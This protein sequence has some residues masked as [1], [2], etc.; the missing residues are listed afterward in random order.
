MAPN[1]YAV[2][3]RRRPRVWFLAFALISSFIFVL[4]WRAVP[5]LST[6]VYAENTSDTMLFQAAPLAEDVDHNRVH[7]PTIVR[8]RLVTVNFATAVEDHVPDEHLP[9]TSERLILNLFD[10]ATFTAT[11]ERVEYHS[12][13]NFTW[14]GTIEHEPQSSVTLVFADGLLVGNIALRNGFYQIRAIDTT[15]HRILQI[16]QSAFPEEDPP[17]V[18]E[19]P[20]DTNSA[21][22]DMTA[23]DDG[24]VIDVMIV[25]TSAARAAEG[26]TTAIRNLLDLIV[27][28]TN[29]GYANSGITQR[30]NLVHMAEVSYSETS[31]S[32]ID[33]IA[34]EDPADGYMDAVHTWRDT[35][36]ADI[37][38]LITESTY[39]GRAALMTTTTIDFAPKAFSV[40]SRTCAS[41]NLSVP[42]EM[43]HN[44]GAQHDRPYAFSAIIYDYAY[45]YV[46]PDYSFR[47]VMAYFNSCPS[48]DCP[49]INYWSNP[50]VT[51]NG[52]ST[53][54]YYSY[55]NAADNRRTLNNTAIYAANW[56]DSSQAPPTAPSNLNVTPVSSTQLILSWNDNSSNESGFEIERAP[57]GSGNWN[58]IATIP[59]N[60]ESYTDNSLT[61]NT[62]YEYR[63]RAYNSS[64][65]S[66]YSNIASATTDACLPTTYTIEGYVND[67]AGNGIGGITIDFGGSQP[68]VTTDS[69]GF[70]SQSG[71]DDGSYIVSVNAISYAFSPYEDLIA[72]SGSDVTHNITGYSF[73]PISPPFSDDFESGSL[74][75]AWA[76]ETDYEGRVQVSSSYPDT[77]S[78]SLLLDD[79][80]GN[81]VKSHAAALLALDLSN[82]SDIDFSFT[83]REF[84]DEDDLDDGVFISDDN[85]ATWQQ[86]FSFN[87]GP[88]TF[89]QETIDLDAA[90]S[91]AGM[92]L[93]SQ[94]LVKF[95]FYDD[96]SV[97]TDGYAIDNVQISAIPALPDTPT[98]LSA[99][100]TSTSQIHLDWI[101]TSDNEDGFTIERSLSDTVG[102]WT[103]IAT[104]GSNAESYDDS[105]LTC[106]TTYYYRISAYNAAG[107][108]PFS[109]VMQTHTSDCPAT[110]YTIE[111]YV[112]D[113]GGN[114]ITGVTVDFAGAQ[115]VVT[116]DSSGYYSQS[117]FTDGNYTVSADSSGYVFSPYEDSV[118]VSSSNVIHDI[119]G[120]TL[121]PVGLPFSDG[122]E[123]GS[124]SSPWAIETDYEG[125]VEISSTYPY[126]GN[127]SLLLDDAAGNL[128][129]SHAAAILALD[130]SGQSNVDLSFIWRGFDDENDTD[131]GIFI[132]DDNGATWQQVFSFNNGPM[133]FTQETIDLD[134]AASAAGRSL[135]S[136]FLVKFQFYDNYP[137]S[138]DGYA[139]DSVQVTGGTTSTANLSMPTF[140]GNPGETIQV[141]IDASDVQGLLATDM[142]I[143]YDSA[144]LAAQSVSTGSLT[145]G[146][147]QQANTTTP[148]Q[149]VI[150]MAGALPASGNGTLATIDFLITGQAGDTSPLQFASVLLNDGAMNATTTDGFVTVN[151][152]SLSGAIRFWNTNS[153]VS[154]VSVTLSGDTS[155]ATS[156]D[157]GG[158]YTLTNLAPGTYT[159]TP[160]RTDGVNGITSFD[161]SLVLQHAVGTTP[162]S[163]HAAIAADVNKSGSINSM[164]AAYIMQYSVG[165]IT[166]PFPGAGTIWEFDLP[167]HS[168]NPLNSSQGNQDFTAIL[169]G[170]PSG[171]WS[172]TSSAPAP[173]S[174]ELPATL[175]LETSEADA[176]GY[177]TTV[178][179]LDDLSIDMYSLDLVLSNSLIN[180]SI[181]TDAR[182]EAYQLVTNLE[183]PDGIRVALAGATPLTED[184]P[185]L[186]IRYK[187]QENHSETE[188]EILLAQINEQVVVNN[189]P[190]SQVFLPLVVN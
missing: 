168:Y 22:P 174:E 4:W 183:A 121:T 107:S 65:S 101:D 119:T 46:A 5:P 16:D 176:Q 89:T 148:G 78:Y 173:A 100:A 150:S 13:T 91:T 134:A 133:S 111:G 8:S 152:L 141:P 90:A 163:G 124:L 75:N 35:Y 160:T 58:T 11:R 138:S 172:N 175:R 71:F 34:L 165:L 53:G 41:G 21:A 60:I 68:S 149:V 88:T 57:T 178:V 49:R 184:G 109:S 115:P 102:S 56:R 146:W 69:S 151:A 31:N 143:T 33:L 32:S 153:A 113:A 26:S 19:V 181:E 118:T 45:G 96:Y 144:V 161:A 51:Y 73:T 12:R 47:T 159:V 117:G 6:N 155:A 1:R 23:N 39:C 59:A 110:D 77:G 98:G 122:F 190:L 182:T 66:S 93:T 2:G 48:Y 156:T 103:P 131:D 185:V 116:T 157:A 85:G 132:S 63:V 25:Y 70:Y 84:S 24:S 20:A 164:D 62:S 64:S 145:S 9:T 127:Y 128:V 166:L 52:Q 97:S 14:I 135:T 67:T 125:R 136:Q 99:Y 106:G 94:F 171:G 50:D 36:Y 167:S 140:S 169:I 80:S 137:V 3:S 188:P 72:V 76:I 74:G 55:A 112:R 83:W 18:D 10:D 126:T 61:C 15:T 44:M 81:S 92:S 40:V 30:I 180:A 54:V 129:Y 37:V 29:T 189:Q 28:E 7:D 142:M 154:G 114:G 79:A 170:D 27:A 17:V 87:N 186:T 95:Q 86:V 187:S 42:H 158:N 120:T 82:Q 147:I 130:L 139:I 179:W 162:L 38:V 104:T 177:R 108:S 123:S 43:G 105:G